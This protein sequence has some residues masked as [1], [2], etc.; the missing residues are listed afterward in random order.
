MLSFIFGQS[1]SSSP[2][3]IPS[4]KE[5]EKKG[6]IEFKTKKLNGKARRVVVVKS[7]PYSM[8][9]LNDLLTY[10]FLR[11]DNGQGDS[12]IADF[13]VVWHKKHGEMKSF[14]KDIFESHI[15]QGRR[16]VFAFD[17]KAEKGDVEIVLGDD[18]VLYVIQ[19]IDKK[20]LYYSF[21]NIP[22]SNASKFYSKW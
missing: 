1:K 12:A 14:K 16:F 17:V 10:N 6:S 13:A 21:N 11:G 9:E 15:A 22:S 3:P 7:E 8:Q 4:K 19:T 18:K 20:K 5:P 2:K